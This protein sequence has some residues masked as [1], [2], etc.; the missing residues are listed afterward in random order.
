MCVN[1][2]STG[3]CGG[4]RATAVPNAT[5][6]GGGVTCHGGDDGPKQAFLGWMV[7]NRSWF[8]KDKYAITLGDGM[9]NKSG[10][11]LTLLP[12]VNGADAVRGK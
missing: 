9:L 11:Y 12:P 5:E 7:Y 10:R 3:L 6:Y 1:R 2:A 4:Q 8:K